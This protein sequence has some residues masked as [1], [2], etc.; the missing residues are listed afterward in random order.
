[1][2]LSPAVA[3][4]NEFDTVN[5]SVTAGGAIKG[6]THS[7]TNEASTV[8]YKI[9]GSTLNITGIYKDVFPRTINIILDDDTHTKVSRY[10]D[11][12]SNYK[13]FYQ[14]YASGGEFLDNEIAIT[15]TD[16]STLTDT[17]EV[18]ILTIRRDW[19]GDINNIKE[20]ARRGKV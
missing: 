3:E 16:P 6:V 20:L 9:L 4:C 2:S 18:F 11:V 19:R 15:Y 13:T 12:P 8:E 1:M 5:I 17:V 14:Y 10:S 7:F